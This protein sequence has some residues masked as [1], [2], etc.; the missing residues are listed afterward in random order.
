M[1]EESAAPQYQ[2]PREFAQMAREAYLKYDAEQWGA[3]A[4]PELPDEED[5]PQPEETPIS[6]SAA[7]KPKLSKNSSKEHGDK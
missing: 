5:Q 7:K 1:D 4:V 2:Y 6:P 3:N